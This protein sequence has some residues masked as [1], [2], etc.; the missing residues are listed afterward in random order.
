M[1]AEGLQA[2]EAGTPQGGA[3]SPLLMNVALHGMEAHLKAEYD[4]EGRIKR[5]C[6][7]TV[8][9]YADDFV[10]IGKSKASCEQATDWLG[11]IGLRLSVE[12]TSIR[13]IKE[14]L[15]FLGTTI[16]MRSSLRHRRGWV[17]H[18]KPS[19]ESIKTFRQEVRATWKRV[20]NR[21]LTQAIQ[22]LN[23]QVLGWGNYHRHYVSKRIFSTLDH[24]MWLR[25][26]RY[27][28][29]LHPHKSWGW[30]IKR[31]W[32]SIP[33]IGDKWVFKDRE[34]G[35]YLLK[36]AWI[37][38]NRH[39]QVKK[40]Y[41]P[42]DPQLRDYWSRRRQRRIPF[43]PQVRMK[44]WRRQKDACPVCQSVLSNGKALH[45]HHIQA[46]KD[47]GSDELSNL[48]L[49]HAACHRQEHSR[50]GK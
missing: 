27:R 37:P 31:Y 10:A 33:S 38:I 18:T 9:R 1:E 17:V 5:K 14:G 7:H 21:P 28:Y 25:Q 6:P 44:L 43:G 3:I 32:G 19:K 39:V 11:K 35:K 34:T 16:S 42:D 48:C 8:A 26:V 49:L 36:L 12:K 41:S 46:K 24:W 13:H 15:D 22:V 40:D 50:Y 20:L 29:R 4:K 2:T 30:C 47:G 45:V 23:S